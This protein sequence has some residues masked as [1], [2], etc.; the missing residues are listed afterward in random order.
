MVCMG[1]RL[2]RR[3]G[4]KMDWIRSEEQLPEINTIVVV[5][6][7]EYCLDLAW[8]DEEGWWVTF[9][10]AYCNNGCF[11]YWCPIPELPEI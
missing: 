2:E 7:Y 5:M 6:D 4:C 1:Q 3:D 11:P 8:R 10:T 9:G